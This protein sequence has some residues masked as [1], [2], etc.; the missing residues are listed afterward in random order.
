M[1]RYF[2]GRNDATGY[3]RGARGIDGNQTVKL[4]H[5]SY[6]GPEFVP[7]QGQ[8][9]ISARVEKAQGVNGGFSGEVSRSNNGIRTAGSRGKTSALPDTFNRPN[10]SGRLVTRGRKSY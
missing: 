7:W 9:D 3:E 10:Q 6:L 8:R 4:S 5:P 2:K 1:S